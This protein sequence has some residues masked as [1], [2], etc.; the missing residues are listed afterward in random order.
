MNLR[1]AF[2]RSACTCPDRRTGIGGSAPTSAA[3]ATARDAADGVLRR[4]GRAGCLRPRLRQLDRGRRAGRCRRAA[5]SRNS[6][7]G[8]GTATCRSISHSPGRQSGPGA[9]DGRDAAR[10]ACG[11]AR[12]A[13]TVVRSAASEAQDSEVCLKLKQSGRELHGDL[14]TRGATCNSGLSLSAC[15]ARPRARSLPMRV[16]AVHSAEG[17][18]AFPRRCADHGDARPRPNAASNAPTACFQA[19]SSKW[20]ATSLLELARSIKLRKHAR[21]HPRRDRPLWHRPARIRRD[22]LDVRKQRP[23]HGRARPSSK[24]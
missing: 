18:R 6:C 17:D 12:V 2:P 24:E 20:A 4:Q 5:P 7:S 19:I 23:Q 11:G 8:S 15:W 10:A 13:R 14:W 22:A 16:L 21:A 9:G 3:P 1:A